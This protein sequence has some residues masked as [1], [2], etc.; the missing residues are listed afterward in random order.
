MA[1][2][3]VTTNAD[4]APATKESI[5]F[6]HPFG[7]QPGKRSLIFVNTALKAVEAA[8]R[9]GK[10]PADKA[11]KWI[12]RCR[13]LVQATGVALIGAMAPFTKDKEKIGFDLPFD[14]AIALELALA[15]FTEGWPENKAAVKAMIDE[16]AD[17][18]RACGGKTK[19]ECF[20]D[21]K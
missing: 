19:F 11:P 13:M 1:K 6:P 17:E 5:T 12:A 8:L 10:I 14:E 9:D 3:N 2:A 15:E 7:S 20:K 4:T 16:N 21:M 18:I